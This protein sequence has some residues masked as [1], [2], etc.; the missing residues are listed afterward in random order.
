MNGF[1][2]A[3]KSIL[4]AERVSMRVAEIFVNVD[5]DMGEPSGAEIRGDEGQREARGR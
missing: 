5:G 3:S 4:A 1:T 2:R